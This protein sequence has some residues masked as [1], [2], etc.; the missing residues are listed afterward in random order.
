MD[1]RSEPREEANAPVVISELGTSRPDPIGGMIEDISGSGMRIKLPYAIACNTP[2][3]I[4]TKD[5]LL[6]GEVARC[7]PVGDEFQLALVIRHSLGNLQDLVRLNQ[8]L[9]GDE[10]A[11]QTVRPAAD[12]TDDDRTDSEDQIAVPVRVNIR[13]R[14][15]ERPL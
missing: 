3:R 10:R 14:S 6:L 4:E 2:V 1:R 9:M 11:D 15:L 8:A 12:E 7:E 13:H 5:M